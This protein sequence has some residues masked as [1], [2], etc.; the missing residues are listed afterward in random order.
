[1]RDPNRP[2]PIVP[3]GFIPGLS[4]ARETI[5]GP[6]MPW[7]G[8]KALEFIEGETF[9]SMHNW[10]DAQTY[11]T[12]QLDRF[13]RGANLDPDVKILDLD[14]EPVARGPKE[15]PTR[16]KQVP[17][18]WPD[19]RPMTFDMPNPD[20]ESIVFDV[21]APE[22][23][24]WSALLTS[25]ETRDEHGVTSGVRRYKASSTKMAAEAMAT[26][27][28]DLSREGAQTEF[29][30]RTW[31]DRTELWSGGPEKFDHFG[32]LQWTRTAKPEAA[33]TK[34]PKCGGTRIGSSGKASDGWATHDWC[35]DCDHVWNEAAPEYEPERTVPVAGDSVVEM[36]SGCEDRIGIVTRVGD[37]AAWFERPDGK[38][39]GANLSYFVNGSKHWR[40]L[41]RPDAEA[42]N[43]LNELSQNRTDMLILTDDA[44]FLR[45]N[46]GPWEKSRRGEFRSRDI[47]RNKNSGWGRGAHEVAAKWLAEVKKAGLL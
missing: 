15:D 22:G 33:P 30:Q 44:V 34:C 1:M 20:C 3:E 14:N 43:Y 12:D 5:L 39:D 29:N 13:L 7:F 42:W 47:V 40:I 32:E 2:Q 41:K 24:E 36:R 11:A 9:H 17:V 28:K 23:R 8:P 21:D 37:G 46:D 10:E 35:M 31:S 16:P 19:H 4:K 45:T 6:L 26:D 38:T 18:F 25:D 27:V